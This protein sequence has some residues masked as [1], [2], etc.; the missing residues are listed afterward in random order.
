MKD[1]LHIAERYFSEAEAAALRSLPE[2]D[3]AAAFFDY[4]TQKEAYIKAIGTG[5]S[6]GLDSVAPAHWNFAR[7]TAG[8]GYTGA[9]AVEGP[10]KLRHA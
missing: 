8:E 5:M 1:L 2:P 3:R 7:I 4:W 6:M 9:V 10:F